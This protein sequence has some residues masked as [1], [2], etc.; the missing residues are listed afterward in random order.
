MKNSPPKIVG[1]KKNPS[2]GERLALIKAAQLYR[3]FTGDEGELVAV[4]KNLQWPTV[5]AVIGSLDGVM[6][7]TVRDGKTEKYVH[8]F[9]KKAKPVLAV[10]PDGKMLVVVLG[11]YRF[12]ERGIEDCK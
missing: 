1:R 12:T 5:A 9:K 2:G 3:A 7:T 11:D 4:V 6:Y 8:Q 10:S